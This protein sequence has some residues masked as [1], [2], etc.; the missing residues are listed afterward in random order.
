MILS[1]SP[2]TCS[3]YESDGSCFES[4]WWT[5][6]Y[7]IRGCDSNPASTGLSSSSASPSAQSSH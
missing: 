4:S 7:P 5:D 2:I 6:L 1:F 3:S